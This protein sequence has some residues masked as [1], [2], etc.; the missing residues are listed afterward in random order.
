MNIVTEK[1]KEIINLLSQDSLVKDVRKVIAATDDEWYRFSS[2]AYNLSLASAKKE[3]KAI[4]K[5]KHVLATSNKEISAIISLNEQLANYALLLPIY[6]T[7]GDFKRIQQLAAKLPY[8][9]PEIIIAI[10]KIT[11]HPKLRVM[12]KKGR[13]EQFEYFKLFTKIHDA[14]LL[15]YYRTNFISCYLTLLPMIE[16]VIIRWIGYT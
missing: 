9:E 8:S 10:G 15:S 3:R 2:K 7:T 4:E 16:G 1:A 5:K 6:S 14:A 13:L 11:M 12:Q